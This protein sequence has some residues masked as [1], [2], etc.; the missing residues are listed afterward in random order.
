MNFRM[1]DSSPG[2]YP[3]DASNTLSR[4]D[5]TVSLQTLP[6][7]PEEELPRAK[8]PDF[9]VSLLTVVV[10]LVSIISPSPGV[11]SVLTL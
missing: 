5:N 10:Y 3:L 8:N 6:D 4:H 11:M 2:L 1:C 7:V 9:K